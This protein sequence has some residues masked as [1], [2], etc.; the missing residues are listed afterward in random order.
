MT[1]R[2]AFIAIVLAVVLALPAL[3]AAQAKP[4]FTGKWIQDME[5]SDPA[6]GG[7]GGGGGGRGPAGPQTI[8][9][10]QT[11]ADLTLERENPNGTI[12]TVYKLD[13]SDSVN[14]NPRG[15]STTKSVWEGA[16]LV[17]TG[18][19][20]RIMQGNEVTM[21]LKEVR[22][23]DADGLMVVV[24]T[25]KSPMGEQTRKNVFKKG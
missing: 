22:S 16:T 8:T 10:T 18:T 24:T 11:A 6:G 14:E 19:Q 4:D 20:T 9:I 5:K 3:S 2:F 21:E 13:G 23:I 15:K 7:P 1:R 25:T 12:K 17:T